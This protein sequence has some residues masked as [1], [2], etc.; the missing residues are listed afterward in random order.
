MSAEKKLPDGWEV[1]RL[2]E[3]CDTGAGGTPL[4]THK[5]Y[6][7]NGIIPWLLSGE[8]SQGDIHKANNYIT[9]KGLNNS[10]AKIF[11]KDTVLVAMYGATAGQVGILHFAAATN[12]AVCGILPNERFIAK[13]LFY[14]FLSRKDQL[15]AQAVGGAQPNIS[16]E[17]IRNTIVPVVSISEQKRI[18]AIL[19]EAFQAIDR[20]KENAKKN[21]A[22]AREVF[23]GYLNQV[24]LSHPMIYFRNYPV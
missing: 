12:Q 10:S 19:D 21:L 8:I 4:K 2:G 18:V 3:V 16:Q 22:N 1:K 7:E 11:P 5:D 17:K 24:F 14:F 23:D 6:Y 20:A 9:E 15:I 13:Y